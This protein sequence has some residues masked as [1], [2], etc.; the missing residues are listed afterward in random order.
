MYVVSKEY[1]CLMSRISSAF[2]CSDCQITGFASERTNIQ[3]IGQSK[4]LMHGEE[5]KVYHCKTEMTD[6]TDSG[7]CPKT[8]WRWWHSFHWLLISIL[9]RREENSWAETKWLIII[10]AAESFA[11]VRFCAWPHVVKEENLRNLA[12][13]QGQYVVCAC[14]SVWVRVTP[15]CTIAFFSRSLSQ[16]A[17]GRLTWAIQL[18]LGNRESC[19]I[20]PLHHF[21]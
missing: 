11:G 10:K 8:Y 14:S 16:Q 15:W 4:Y 1:F 12:M 19:L 13:S 20:L 2:F 21:C 7:S 18:Y 9:R 3:P 17:K 6:L 5:I